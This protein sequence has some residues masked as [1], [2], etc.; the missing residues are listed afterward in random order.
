MTTFKNAVQSTPTFTRTENGMKTLTSSLNALVDLFFTIG[1]SRGKDVTCQFER[2]YA[3][4]RSLA[5]K[6]A[7]WTR[8]VRGGAGEREIF[9]S[10]I[11]HLEATHPSEL[12]QVIELTPEYGRWDD[13]L[14]V[15]TESVSRSVAERIKKALL[16]EKNGLC[17]KWMPRK[18][19]DAV[20]LRNAMGMSP[21]QYRKTLVTLTKVV[22]QNMCSGTW[23][24]INYSHVPS[25][26]A[27]RYQKAFGKHDPSGYAQYREQLVTGEAKVNA[28]AVYPYDVLK[29]LKMGNPAIEVINAQWE[30]LPNYVGE[31]SILPM[32][33]VSGSMS[34]H[35]VNPSVTALDVAISLG[36]YLSDKNVGSFK[37]M[38][39]T[40][41]G[42]SKIEVL[43][44]N[45]VSKYNQLARAQW[46]M[47]TD[48]HSA[49]EEVL[50]V[51]TMNKV[52]PEQMPQYILILSDME[53]DAC[54]SYDDSAIEMIR[55]KY[56]NAGYKVPKI[57][58]WNLVSRHANVPVRYNETGT[59]LISGFSPS[60]MTSVL[61][62]ETFTPESVMLT[63]L[64]SD[65]YSKVV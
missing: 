47:N 39:L 8:D 18:G 23:D 5:M 29:T 13:L 21:K 45:I 3:Q 11:R 41:S 65:R 22:E 56:E 40:F 19:S 46:D 4:D 31:A 63:T 37:D 33:D 10:I 16:V 20:A 55:R 12:N 49:F 64:L 52:A 26:A 42:K 38:F 59:A 57:V 9:R 43:Q 34:G 50:R 14:V 36:L 58:F 48:L 7:F 53:F 51:A 6:L 44:G 60:I 15:R 32:V 54:V 61:K 28:N 30:A 62:A 1:A 17:A 24:Q 27:A 35:P 25:V 2:A